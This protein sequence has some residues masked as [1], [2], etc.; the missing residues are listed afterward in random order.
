MTKQRSGTD[1]NKLL[2][3]KCG[4]EMK[5]EPAFSPNFCG[6]RAVAS[7][8]SGCEFTRQE[9]ERLNLKAGD[10]FFI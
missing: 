6:F 2:C 10:Q 1:K 8:T 5:T 3:P 7:C 4:R 9:Q